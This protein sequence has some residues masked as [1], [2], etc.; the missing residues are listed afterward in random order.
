[1]ISARGAIRMSHPVKSRKCGGHSCVPPCPSLLV[2]GLVMKPK[3]IFT[4]ITRTLVGTLVAY[5]L[6]WEQMVSL[7]DPRYIPRLKLYGQYGREKIV[8]LYCHSP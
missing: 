3:V 4:R 6:V 1:M 8:L 2:F 7:G 5:S